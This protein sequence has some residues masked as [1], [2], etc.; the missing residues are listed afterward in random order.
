MDR[1]TEDKI[2]SCS[3]NDGCAPDL[4]DG[5]AIVD[6]VRQVKVGQGILEVPHL[7]TCECGN[8]FYMV[9]YEE[10]CPVCG[11]VYGVTPCSS[12]TKENIKPAGI[13]Y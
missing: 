12:H 11:M 1:K 13:N 2:K 5:K 7:M 6:K 10:K 4:N 3:G 9:H 8:G